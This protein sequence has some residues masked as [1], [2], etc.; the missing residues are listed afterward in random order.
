MKKMIVMAAAMM[1]AVASQA[2][3]LD[4][5]YSGVEADV[6]ATVYV[7]MGSEAVSSW[8]SQDAV[9]AKAVSQA[10]VVKKIKTYT[11]QGS[12]TD[13][14]ITKSSA[15]IYYVIVSADGNTFG[16]TSVSDM[17]ASVYDPAN[18]ETSPGQNTSLSSASVAKSGIAWGTG[19][20]D[21][22][23]PTP[24]PDVPEPTSGL[25]LVLGGA[26][27]ALRRKQK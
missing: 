7:L 1:I 12:F 11:A 3:A 8:E 16:V 27:L 9:A 5:K 24:T 6:G 13:D 10:S 26:A 2:M 22:V 18:Q 20:T 25:L 4:W 19:T 23:V 14:G 17:T 21:P 15:S